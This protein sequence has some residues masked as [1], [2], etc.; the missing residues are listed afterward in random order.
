MGEDG[1]TGIPTMPPRA[2]GLRIL[3]GRTFRQ[4]WRDIKN[5]GV[6]K[7]YLPPMRGGFVIRRL[8]A[9][10]ARYTPPLFPF[11]LCVGLMRLAAVQ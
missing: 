4:A 9:Q 6:E 2:R 5:S 7:R 8:A 3:S 11:R 10:N 1:A